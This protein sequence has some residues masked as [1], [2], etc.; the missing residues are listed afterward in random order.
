M[1][2]DSFEAYDQ[3]GHRSW[4]Q[5]FLQN[6]GE[7]VFCGHHMRE[8]TPKLRDEGAVILDYSDGVLA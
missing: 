3:C 5:V 1:G 6:G 4:A 7:L 8:N 2:N